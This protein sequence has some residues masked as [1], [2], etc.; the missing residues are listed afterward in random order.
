[1]KNLKCDICGY[2]R[3]TCYD[4]RRWKVGDVVKFKQEHIENHKRWVK[5]F[6]AGNI[7]GRSFPGV[8]ELELLPEGRFN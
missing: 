5:E 4:Q 8:S 2:D 3:G 6:G 1:M 7:P